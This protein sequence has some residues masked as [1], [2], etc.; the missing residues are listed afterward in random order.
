MRFMWKIPIK[1]RL[2]VLGMVLV[3]GI[4]CYCASYCAYLVIN[5]YSV[6]YDYMIQFLS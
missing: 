6:S 4:E 2:S 3:L 1:Y 5:M